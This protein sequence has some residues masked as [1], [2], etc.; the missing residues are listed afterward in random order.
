M[1]RELLQSNATFQTSIRYL[2]QQLQGMTEDVDE[3]LYSIEYEMLKAGKESRVKISIM[4]QPLCTAVQ[5]AL[6]DRFKSVG[7][8]P[9]AVVGHSSGVIAAAYPADSLTAQEALVQ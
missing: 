7:I 1:G 6:V 5:I 8:T 2:D 9:K 4:S 3:A